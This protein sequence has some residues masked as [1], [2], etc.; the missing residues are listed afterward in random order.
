[1]STPPKQILINKKLIPPGGLRVKCPYCE[2]MPY[3]SEPT[4]KDLEAWVRDHSAGMNHPEWDFQTQLCELLP[5]GSCTYENGHA[6]VSVDCRVNGESLL[7]GTKGVTAY[8][9][10]ALTG[11][12]YVSQEEAERRAA[13]CTRCRMNIQAEGCRGCSVFAQLSD[14][15]G[16]VRGDRKTSNDHLLYACCVCK[17]S[18]PTIVFI[19]NEVLAKGMSDEQRT[20]LEMLAPFCWKLD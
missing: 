14:A 12:P 2:E 7:M 18:I 9:W 4:W 5:P 19:K 10:E 3:H 6:A 1:M 15:V 13:I 17:C 8:L 16:S 11:D 20:Q